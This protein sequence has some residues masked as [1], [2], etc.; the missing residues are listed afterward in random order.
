MV[1]FFVV[2]VNMGNFSGVFSVVR[3]WRSFSL[4]L[5][6][7]FVGVLFFRFVRFVPVFKL[8]LFL[9]V[10][11]QGTSFFRVYSTIHRRRLL[12]RLKDRIHPRSST[13]FV[14]I[15]GASHVA[16]WIVSPAILA[17]RVATETLGSVLNTSVSKAQR[18]TFILAQLG[19]HG[20]RAAPRVR[21][22]PWVFVFVAA[23]IL[24][25]PSRRED[26]G[27]DRVGPGAPTD[28]PLGSV[29]R[30]RHCAACWSSVFPI[31]VAA[32]TLASVLHPIVTV[33]P[34]EW[35]TLLDCH[36]RRTCCHEW[37]ISCVLIFK[38]AN[39]IPG[40]K[41]EDSIGPCSSTSLA[42]LSVTSVGAA[43]GRAIFSVGVSTIALI[44]VL[45]TCVQVVVL[46]TGGDAV[47]KCHI[48]VENHDLWQISG[49]FIS[50]TSK[51]HAREAFTDGDTRVGFSAA[52]VTVARIPRRKRTREIRHHPRGCRIW[53]T[54]SYGLKPTISRRRGVA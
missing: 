34:T 5:E 19:S 10:I 32:K 53:S 38:T 44:P 31:G 20:I 51:I 45:G 2:L 39:V 4:F 6:R 28:L 29:S 27:I 42:P 40:E 24:G 1:L 25:T 49:R 11:L 46:L 36:A 15:S 50:K 47:P 18:S 30:A 12:E 17:V 43:S 33:P 41:R 52:I 21:E 16:L 54:V 37:Q 14:W 48:V 8:H 23:K 13:V 3:V 26:V 35:L 22:I 9:L 7:V